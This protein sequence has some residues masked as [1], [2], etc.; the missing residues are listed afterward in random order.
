LLEI[1]VLGPILTSESDD[2]IRV[3]RFFDFNEPI[4]IERPDL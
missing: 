3:I 2:V 4:E 1:E